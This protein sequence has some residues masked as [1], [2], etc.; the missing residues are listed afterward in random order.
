MQQ[1]SEHAA[2]TIVTHLPSPS[3]STAAL[4]S[5]GGALPTHTSN[6][7]R[8]KITVLARANEQAGTFA[9]LADQSSDHGAYMKERQ[10]TQPSNKESTIQFNASSIHV[11]TTWAAAATSV[12]HDTPPSSVMSARNCNI[13]PVTDLLLRTWRP[14]AEAAVQT[15]NSNH[16]T[17]ITTQAGRHSP[18]ATA[19]PMLAPS[20][21]PK[22][23]AGP[24]T[25]ASLPARQKLKPRTCRLAEQYNRSLIANP[26]RSARHG[27]HQRGTRQEVATQT[28]H[29][30]EPFCLIM[31]LAAPD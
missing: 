15:Y 17:T 20:E 16:P 25:H 24:H 27:I 1:S 21:T 12:L 5:R 28:T 13:E 2:I 18:P 6:Q 10:K 3:S 11:C 29:D 23:P 31:Q 22:P 30:R 19:R 4:S 26:H 7:Q 8:M 14:L 9:E